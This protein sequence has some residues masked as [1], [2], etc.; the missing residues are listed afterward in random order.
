MLEG[1]KA[2]LDQLL[3]DGSRGDPRAYAAGLKE[4]VVEARLG[5]RSMQEALTATETELAA[6]RQQLDDAERRGRLA[7]MVPDPE[8][9][10]I[11]DRYAVRHRERVVI[12]ERKMAVQREELA[13]AEREVAEMTAEAKRAVASHPSETI[14]AAWRDLESAGGTRPDEDERRQAESERQRRESAIEAQ[15]AYLKR[16][17]GKQ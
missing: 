3:R 13:L 9:V 4:A 8:T 11:A 2:R 16:K 6:E 15:L 17:L 12:L 5:V 7:A 1:L 14:A 10:R